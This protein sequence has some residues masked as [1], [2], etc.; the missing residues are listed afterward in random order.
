MKPAKKLVFLR[1]SSLGDIAISIP[2]IRCFLS[3]YP[4]FRINFVTKKNFVPLLDEFKDIDIL[5]LDF[6]GKHRGLKGLFALYKEIKELN[7]T[8]VVDLHGS[9]RTSILRLFFFFS[10][11][12][13][14]KIHKG[15]IEKKSLTRKNNKI[16][17]PLTPTIH[18]Y[19]EVLRKIGFPVD[20]SGHEFPS[21]FITPKKFNDSFFNSN[22]KWIGIAPF[23]KH[24]GKVYPFDLIQKVISFL[25][26]E[27]QVFLFGSHGDEANKLKVWERAYSNVYSLAG[28]YSLSDQIKIIS[29]L[30][31]MISMDSANG[32]IATNYNIPV[33]TI[34]GITHPYA[35][36]S[37]WNQNSQRSILSDRSLYPLIPTSVYGNVCPEGYEDCMRTIP[38]EKI[39]EVVNKT[40]FQTSS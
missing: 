8:G 4:D 28:K 9:L 3:K 23:A 38:P 36:F 17:V 37:P 24:A 34:W 29:N 7:P 11:I 1:F 6:S 21:K 25:Q 31:I 20:L 35:G 15:R 10:S 5:E 19:G 13:F 40:M 2:L 39:I 32:H 12:R 30:D 26:I 18:R 22:L 16:L 33:I 14:K 27:N